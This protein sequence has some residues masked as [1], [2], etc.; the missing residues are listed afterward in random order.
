MVNCPKCQFNQPKDRF[1][2]N[3]GIDMDAY[4]PAQRPLIFRLLQNWIFQLCTLTGV[5]VLGFGL[6]R[7]QNRAR[8]VDSLSAFEKAATSKVNSSISSSLN[9]PATAQRNFLSKTPTAQVD[10]TLRSLPLQNAAAEQTAAPETSTTSGNVLANATAAS[11]PQT[12]AAPQT[13]TGVSRIAEALAGDVSPI[14]TKLKLTFTEVSRTTLAGLANESRSIASFG[15]Y[16]SAMI[17]EREEKLKLDTSVG[18]LTILDSAS[19]L[20]LKL[21]QPIVLFKGSRDPQLDQNIGLNFKEIF[22]SHICRPPVYFEIK[23]SA[24]RAPSKK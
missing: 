23:T 20:Q 18:G 3:C 4:R 17:P 16:L 22:I 10:S 24:F 19:D 15:T 6:I 8:I 14:P 21:N 7:A 11:Q 12:P 2:A 1:C 13:Q 5:V 9:G